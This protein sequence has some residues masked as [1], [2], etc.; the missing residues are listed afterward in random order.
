M[1]DPTHADYSCVKSNIVVIG[2]V[3]TWDSNRLLNRPSDDS[4]NLPNIG[5][6]LKVV[7][8]FEAGL[9]RSY[10]DGQNATRST[11]N[12]NSTLNYT[13]SYGVT[14]NGPIIG[15]AYWAHTHDI[16]GANWTAGTGPALQRRGLR[17][18]TFTFDVNEFAQQTNP[19]VR[20]YGNQFFTAAKYGGFE[21]DASN[22]GRRPSNT[23][24]NPFRRDNGT[25]DK[26][27][28]EDDDPSPARI[29]EAQTYFL[30]SDARGVL[31]SFDSIFNTISTQARSIAG[32]A[33]TN[34]SLTAGGTSIFQASFDTG[35]WSGDLVSQPLTQSSTTAVLGATPNWSAADRLGL[36]SNPASSRK[37]VMGRS[38]ANAIPKATNFTWGLPAGGFGGGVDTSVRNALDRSSPSAAADGLG[39][40]RLNYLRGDRSKEKSPFR[41]RNRL[42]GDIVNSGAA[43]TGAPTTTISDSSYPGFYKDNATRAPMVFV[44]A[45]DGM[46]HAFNANTGDEA[47]AYIPSWLAPRLSALTDPGYVGNHQSYV[48]GQ[49]AVAEAKLG[50]AGTKAD[51]AT[52]LVGATGNGGQGVF[53][54]NVTTPTA[55]G[56]DQVMWE[57]TDADDPDM[58]NVVGR[59]QI[60]KFRTSAPGTAPATFKY[61]AVVG[62]GVNNYVAD[63]RA[64]ATGNPVLF[65]LDLAKPA[66]DAWVQGSNYFKVVLP[67][68]A[69]LALTL[70]P[71]LVNFA[72]A[73]GPGG[74]VTQIYMGDLHGNLWK[75][76]FSL[77]GSTNWN[78]AKLSTFNKGTAS[79]PLPYPLFIAKDAANRVQ[80][81]TMA[82]A[83]AYGPTPESTYVLFGTG[84]YLERGDRLPA[85]TNSMYT[86]FDNGSAA[87]DGGSP[88]GDAAIRSRARL[89]AGT[90]NATTGAVTVSGFTWGRAASD[91]DPNQRSGW[92]ADFPIAGERQVSNAK[93]L[94]RSTL[95]IFGSLIPGSASTIAACTADPGS[96]NEY[97]VDFSNG[98][99]TSIASTVG[100]LGEPLTIEITAATVNTYTDST[101]KRIRT[102]MN[103]VI[104]QGS[105]GL[106]LGRTAQSDVRNGRLSW[107]QINNYL[108]LKNAP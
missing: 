30:Q 77:Y 53:A 68:N 45:N 16:R 55:F 59:P 96:G 4:Q 66:T 22:P 65:L 21:T 26:Y 78:M 82:P 94:P 50:S 84:K 101:G 100:I 87:A 64:S 91:T 36:L 20:R 5:Y 71:G 90:V 9:V 73:G 3:N 38:G 95:A 97:T 54:L 24:G 23:Q 15:S 107:R 44:G 102:T 75:L 51:W 17:V 83:I 88:V 63:G 58:G 70:P 49:I 56:P 34:S 79:S 69:T 13:T 7:Q 46:L 40:D 98:S 11:G 62:S 1:A 67:M 86:V 14:G 18:K 61:F 29:G 2:D 28:W 42:L 19:A 103:Q 33:S 31:Q 37:I 74:Q 43:Y 52:V 92:Y 93:I 32:S 10:L 27:V 47:F 41:S 12:P 99:G 48:D 76:D 89:Q 106:S 35:D 104:Q 39:Q 108:D 6:W 72:P 81:I 25:F 60:L 57:F 8:D 85:N 80:P 105:K